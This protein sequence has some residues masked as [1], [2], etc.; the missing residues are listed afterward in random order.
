MRPRLAWTAGIVWMTI[1]AQ[2]AVALAG[3]ST[4]REERIREAAR[5]VERVAAPFGEAEANERL[6]AVF[7]VK[8]RT[9]SDLRDQKLNLGEVAVV[10][11]L[12]EVGHTSPDTVLSLWASGRLNWGEIAERLKVDLRD[13]LRRLETTRRELGRLGP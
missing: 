6:A 5:R 4:A 9:L 7:R 11:A 8:P 13:L 12:A 1:L 10:L 2:G 3:Q